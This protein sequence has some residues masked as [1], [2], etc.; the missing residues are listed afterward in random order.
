MREPL[1]NRRINQTQTFER[2]GIRITLTVGFYPNGVPG[3][4]FLNADRAD[5]ML[6]VLMSDAAIVA[7]IALQHG[8][9]L[10][11]IAHALKRDKFGIASSPF[12]AAIDRITDL[13][14][15]DAEK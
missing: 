15:I 3:E 5:S 2:D 8:V 13:E 10:Q 4:V 11:Q 12:G 9:P 1:H 14:V 6:D 7:S